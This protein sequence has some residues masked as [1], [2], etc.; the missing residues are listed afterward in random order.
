MQNLCLVSWHCRLQLGEDDAVQQADNACS[1]AVAVLAVIGVHDARVA[2]VRHKQNLH[3]RWSLPKWSISSAAPA[4]PPPFQCSADDIVD[5][6][7]IRTEGFAHGLVN[8]ETSSR[9]DD[10][11]DG[12]RFCIFATTPVHVML[13]MR[14]LRSSCR[15]RTSSERESAALSGEIEAIRLTM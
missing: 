5:W 6:D 2:I 8:A 14:D 15:L 1:R 12:G 4:D 11:N 3:A 13:Y 7:S 9:H 10:D